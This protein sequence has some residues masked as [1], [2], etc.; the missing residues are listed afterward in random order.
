MLIAFLRQL[1]VFLVYFLMIPKLSKS[2]PIGRPEGPPQEHVIISARPIGSTPVGQKNGLGPESMGRPPLGSLFPLYLRAETHPFARKRT[3][4]LSVDANR[5]IRRTRQPSSESANFFV[6]E[7]RPAHQK[8]RR[9]KDRRLFPS[10]AITTVDLV[11]SG[12]ADQPA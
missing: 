11:V 1:A 7:P 3:P 10:A 12:G 9:P 5:P 4:N 6:T 2:K 8:S